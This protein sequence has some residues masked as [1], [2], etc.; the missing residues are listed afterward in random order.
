MHAATTTI[1]YE[2]FHFATALATDENFRLV[3]R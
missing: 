3:I 1:V 2:L